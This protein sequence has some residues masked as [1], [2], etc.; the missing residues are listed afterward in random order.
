[1]TTSSEIATRALRRLGIVRPDETPSAEDSASALAALEEITAEW[2][3]DGMIFPETEY[4][5][6]SRFQSGV[7]AILALRLTDEFGKSPTA[8]LVAD[9]KTGRERLNGAYFVVPQA[10]FDA[11][12]LSMPAAYGTRGYSLEG[13]SQ[14][15]VF[16]E[17]W[18]SGTAYE[19]GSTVESG[20]RLYRCIV[21]GTSG[22]TAPTGTGSDIDD[23]TCT[24]AFVRMKG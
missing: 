10:S 14:T 17:A 24:W 18:A 22:V 13:Q 6:D 4:P 20:D 23:G 2:V 21:S 19:I 15:P 7:I 11:G 3:G 9:A 1:M 12:L 5:L 8:M 16:D